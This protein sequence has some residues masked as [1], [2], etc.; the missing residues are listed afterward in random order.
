M[1]WILLGWAIPHFIF[2]WLTGEK[3]LIKYKWGCFCFEK[4]FQKKKKKNHHV[5]PVLF[6]LYVFSHC[7]ADRIFGA[8]TIYIYISD[9]KIRPISLLPCS[10]HISS[11][12]SSLQIRRA[13]LVQSVDLCSQ[14][15]AEKWGKIENILLQT[16]SGQLT[17]RVTWHNLWGWPSF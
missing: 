13:L 1:I 8:C 3:E 14:L 17:Q 5:H 12:Y 7:K 16:L 6:G 9:M 11:E 2:H 15:L 10:E 4:L